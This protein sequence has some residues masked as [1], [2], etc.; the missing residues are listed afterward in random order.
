MVTQ[1]AAIR[2]LNAVMAAT[3]LE[4]VRNMRAFITT[5][6]ID[7][8]EQMVFHQGM[9]LLALLLC[10]ISAVKDFHVHMH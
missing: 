1:D 3:N 5:R 4:G 6:L 9:I 8:Y 2:G 7:H 10:T